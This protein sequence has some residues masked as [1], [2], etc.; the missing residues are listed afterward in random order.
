ML[1]APVHTL[2]RPRPR[3]RLFRAQNLPFCPPI[4][5]IPALIRPFRPSILPLCPFDGPFRA[6]NAPFPGHFSLFSPLNATLRPQ[7][8]LFRAPI[9]PV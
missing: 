4:R 7:S 5:T 2:S 8:R 1:A 3:V 6:Q 9:Q